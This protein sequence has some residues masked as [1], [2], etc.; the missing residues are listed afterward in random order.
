M[1]VVISYPQKG[2][3]EYL[4]HPGRWFA[5]EEELAH[6]LTDYRSSLSR[7]YAKKFNFYFQSLSAGAKTV[8]SLMTMRAFLTSARP[9]TNVNLPDELPCNVPIPEQVHSSFCCPILKV[10]STENVSKLNSFFRILCLFRIHLLDY[11][12]AM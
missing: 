12:V 6:A 9:G 11:A 3:Y 7:M 2:P 8:P 1:F 4:F 10:Q 5:L